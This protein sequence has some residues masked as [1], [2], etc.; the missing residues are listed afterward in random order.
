MIHPM[1][2]DWETGNTTLEALL[3]DGEADEYPYIDIYAPDVLGTRTLLDIGDYVDCPQSSGGD[4][5]TIGG[6]VEDQ[7]QGFQ[8][9]SDESSLG[10]VFGI[11]T[12]PNNSTGGSTN[13][14]YALPQFN[15][16]FQGLSTMITAKSDGTNG[17]P[18]T[19]D[20]THGKRFSV[21]ISSIIVMVEA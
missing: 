17:T 7:F 5:D 13:S 19:G 20:T 9:G 2:R 3:K 1:D 12:N 16:T 15:T 11:A 8:I 18:R 4:A 21:G 6:L 10:D 14:N